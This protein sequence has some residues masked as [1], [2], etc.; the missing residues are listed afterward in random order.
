MVFTLAN[1]NAIYTGNAVV[2][3][4]EDRGWIL[5]HFFEG[6]D[7]LRT[8]SEV[9][10]KWGVHRAGERRQSWSPADPRRTLTILV[11][12]RMTVVFPDRDAVLQAP[13]DYALW[14]D[15]AHEWYVDLDTVA[16]TIRWPSKY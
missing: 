10:V 7:E 14:S 6:R 8:T 3:G 1:L 16:L 4:V 13:G 12:G 15:V 2:D 11:S 5:G 9:E